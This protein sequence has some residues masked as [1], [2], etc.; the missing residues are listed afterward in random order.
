MASPALIYAATK[1]AGSKN[2]RK[3]I[4]TVC[5][6]VV[7]ILF[8]PVI[9]ISSALSVF[10]G[11]GNIGSAEMDL[12]STLLYQEVR[13]IYAEYVEEMK[14]KMLEKNR[15][16]TEQNMDYDYFDETDP[17]TGETKKV[18]K[19][20]CTVDV[21][22]RFNHINTAYLFAVM[23]CSRTSEFM[24][25]KDPYMPS[26]EEL[27]DF[28]D[29][30]APFTIDESETDSGRTAYAIYNDL[31]SA[32]EIAEAFFPA[33]E[34]RERFLEAVYLI[35]QRIGDEEYDENIYVCDN[36]NRMAIPLYYQYGSPWGSMKYGN[37]TIAKNGCAP[38]CIAMV[39]SYLQAREIYPNDITDFTGNRYYVN[40]AGSSWDIFSACAAHWGI[41]CTYIG[42]SGERIA[43]ELSKGH[44]VI[45][46]MGPG[47]FTSAGHFI[48][49]TGIDEDGKVT[50]NDPNDSSKKDH[51]NKKF[52][53]SLITT[54]AKGGWSFY[55]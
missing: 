25:R 38:T 23:S 15:E 52:S 24:S 19:W 7:V 9:V 34:D 35:R 51:I 37:G 21:S 1:A 17:A 8:L 32:E 36:P 53:L 27:Y 28:W 13:S 22:Y 49:L 54:E 43:G 42:S 31:M 39:F 50:V 14:E 55:Y 6:A 3:I 44:P 29:T 20:Y 45:L 30:I 11:Y 47:T 48:V 18:M 12:Q 26:K 4:L 40:G 46:S 33:E 41:S 5:I 10:N 16:I 2:G